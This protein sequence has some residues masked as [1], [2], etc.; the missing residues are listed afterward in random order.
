MVVRRP[1]AERLPNQGHY[2]NA[3]V[4]YKRF[5]PAGPDHAQIAASAGMADYVDDLYAHHF[6]ARSEN[7]S[8]MWSARAPLPPPRGEVEIRAAKFGRGAPLPLVQ[9]SKSNGLTPTQNRF[10]VLASPQGGGGSSMSSAFQS[11]SAEIVPQA[12]EGRRARAVHDLMRSHETALLAPLL[13][14]LATKNSVRVLG[15][16]DAGLRMPTV[17]LLLK[18]PGADAAARLSAEGICCGGG[19]FYAV[20]CLEAQ[21]IDPGH[22]V[23]RVS[24]VHYTAK[25]EIDRLIAALDRAL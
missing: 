12:G 15:P 2:F 21:G 10:A 13:D 23:L 5:T 18:E 24:F 7:E 3:G 1:L 22:G 25:G 20:R 17:A 14:Y 8:N 16:R 9:Q 6:G 19:D 11:S 4:R